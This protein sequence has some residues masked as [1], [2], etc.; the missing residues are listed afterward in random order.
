MQGKYHNKKCFFDGEIYD[1]KFEAERSWQLKMLVRGGKIRALER[2]KEFILLDG[3]VNNKGE[4]IRPIKYVADFYYYDV[5]E[6]V[7]VV[8]DTKGYAT[9]V[10]KLKKKMFE[11][12]YPDIEF[13]EIRKPRKREN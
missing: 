12:R 9:E 7:L 8:E 11:K 2:Q 6:D 1:S 3:Y 13:R 4:K 5:E 10:Y